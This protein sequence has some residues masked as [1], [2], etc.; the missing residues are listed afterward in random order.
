MDASALGAS[1]YTLQASRSFLDTT[2]EN[3]RPLA[4][5][6]EGYY[7]DHICGQLADKYPNSVVKKYPA[8]LRVT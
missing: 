6:M 1:E 8:S 4:V 7:P 2:T 5:Q 3:I